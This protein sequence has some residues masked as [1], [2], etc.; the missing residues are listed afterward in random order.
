MISGILRYTK[1]VE[2]NGNGSFP[3][4]YFSYSFRLAVSEEMQ[5]TARAV[6]ITESI[7]THYNLMLVQLGVAF[8][9]KPEKIG[10]LLVCF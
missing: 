4:R 10:S 5:P 9:T 3:S 1:I 8:G 2:F 6:A 7:C